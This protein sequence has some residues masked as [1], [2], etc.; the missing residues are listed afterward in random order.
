L[1][2]KPIKELRFIKEFCCDDLPDL[3]D[4][5]F[6]VLESLELKKGASLNTN[7]TWFLI[8]EVHRYCKQVMVL[9]TGH[10]GETRS[11]KSEMAQLLAL[12][13][14]YFFNDLFVKGHFDKID[15]GIKKG[16]V[17]LTKDNIHANDQHY[18]ESIRSSFRDHSLVYGAVNVID[19]REII[20]GGLG[21]MTAIS[22]VN[23][24]NNIIAKYNQGE[25][26]IYPKNFIDMNL[27]YGV[28]WFIK[29]VKKRVN[30]GLLY[31]IGSSSYGM[32]KETF[33]GWVCLPL[34]QNN[35]L[36][37][38]YEKKKNAWIEKVIRGGGDSRALLRLDAAELLAKDK[39]FCRMKSENR[40]YLTNDQQLD[41]IDTL[42]IKGDL[43]NFNSEER[44][45][46][47]GRAQLIVKMM[48]FPEEFS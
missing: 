28:H 47:V 6:D 31:K 13:H 26:W 10:M 48:A 15:V 39:M 20:G 44:K 5:H 16:E 19:E 9:R 14:T 1:A 42:V 2:Y 30:W 23:N 17:E 24:Y 33:L 7:R 40:F 29:D 45:R 18:L 46:I 8:Q 38:S 22:E 25:H 36:R 34:H 21:S 37:L 3:E 12:I 27:A 41:I 11:G 43:P 35:N 32:H 4:H